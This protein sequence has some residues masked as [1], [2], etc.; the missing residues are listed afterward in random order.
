M[1]DG[2]FIITKTTRFI[3]IPVPLN[4]IDEEYKLSIWPIV[5]FLIQLM[6]NKEYNSAQRHVQVQPST[7][8]H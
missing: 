5:V 8:N 6:N 2:F 4:Q 7:I 1:L 3:T